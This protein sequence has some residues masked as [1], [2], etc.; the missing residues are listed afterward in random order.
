MP[1][2]DLAREELNR[3]MDRLEAEL[4]RIEEEAKGLEAKLKELFPH[5]KV[6]MEYRRCGKASCHCAK[7]ELHGPY[8]YAYYKQG[9]KTKAIYF[10]RKHPTLPEGAIPPAAYRDLA[11]AAERLRSRREK[12][13]E[14]VAKAQDVLASALKPSHKG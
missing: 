8:Y 12:I 6:R 1:R 7:G 10:G 4:L 5:P 14:A 3:L 9:G 13:N 2:L 11:R